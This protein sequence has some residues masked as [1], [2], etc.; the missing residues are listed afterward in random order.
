LAV[1]PRELLS[2]VILSLAA[3]IWGFSLI[4]GKSEIQVQEYLLLLGLYGLA[5]GMFVIPR[6]RANSTRLFDLPVFI[7]VVAFLR[8]GLIPLYFFFHPELRIHGFLNDPAL[9]TQALFYLIVGMVAFWLGSILVGSG[10]G[11]GENTES[12]VPG[13]TDMAKDTRPLVWATGLYLVATATKIYLLYSHMY[14]FTGSLDIYQQNLA[15]MQVLA[16]VSQF[17]SPALVMA[18]VDAYSHPHD[19]MRKR[20]FHVLFASECFWGLLSG[21]KTFLLQNFILVGLVSSLVQRRLRLKWILTPPLMLLLIYPF[22]NRYRAL[23]RAGGEEVTSVGSAM[24]VGWQAVTN[25]VEQT[26]SVGDWLGSGSD[27][28]LA[29][30]DLLQSVA[31]I[32]HIGALADSMRTRGYWWMLPIYPF[33]PRLVWPSKPA[34]TMGKDFSIVLH[35]DPNSASSPTY[36]GD[37]YLEFGLAGVVVCMLVLGMFCKWLTRL[38][39]SLLSKRHLFVFVS[40]F[41]I[42]I[43]MDDDVFGYWT[44]VIKY[45]AMISLVAWLV[46]RPSAGGSRFASRRPAAS[47]QRSST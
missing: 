36:V 28:S 4:E 24:T 14:S 43:D 23:I 6:V 1:R 40:M 15:W 7:T 26:Q 46:Y 16:V 32:V 3:A 38:G 39:T 17:G 2:L 5:S 13:V 18:A 44:G 20:F 34:E 35:E 42:A 37:A 11:V 19:R 21:M 33:I 29:R 25:T 10:K 30:L 27:S 47:P 22:H 8:F 12:S 31:T 41:L 45:L 9:F